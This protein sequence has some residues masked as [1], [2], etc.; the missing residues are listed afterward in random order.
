MILQCGRPR[1]R[2]P[3]RH[4]RKSGWSPQTP[5]PRGCT[6]DRKH[7]LEAF[8]DGVF[9][10]VITLL[11]LNVHL[12]RQHELTLNALRKLLPDI[13]AFVLSFVIVGVYW[14]AP[15]LARPHQILR[16]P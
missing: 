15:S 7:R 5:A 16:C 6:Q 13:M 9:A 2:W 4:P 12:E 8:S 1:S 11:V 3:P 10:I 14:V